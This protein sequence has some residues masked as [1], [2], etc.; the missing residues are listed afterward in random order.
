MTTTSRSDIHMGSLATR[1]HLVEEK[2]KAAGTSD[3]DLLMRLWNIIFEIAATEYDGSAVSGTP[4]DPTVFDD[5][6]H[7]GGLVRAIWGVGSSGLASQALIGSR[8]PDGRSFYEQVFVGAS[9]PSD[10]WT[11]T[12]TVLGDIAALRADLDSHVADLQ[13]QIDSL[14]V[15]VTAMGG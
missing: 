6:T 7:V 12:K 9:N 13:S 3:H 14:N 5:Y 10:Y 11:G 4:S 8:A 15:R 1:L 2:V